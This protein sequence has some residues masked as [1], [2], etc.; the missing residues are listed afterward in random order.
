[1]VVIKVRTR[2]CDVIIRSDKIVK[3]AERSSGRRLERRLSVE[4]RLGMSF[5]LGYRHESKRRPREVGS[6]R[7]A[8]TYSSL[9]HLEEGGTSGNCLSWRVYG[10]FPNS[11]KE[12]WESA[13]GS[14]TGRNDCQW[15]VLERSTK[16]PKTITGHA[17]ECHSN[18]QDTA[19]SGT[20]SRQDEMVTQGSFHFFLK[21]KKNLYIFLKI[22]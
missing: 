3:T 19:L 20:M 22:K 7:L 21:K 16:T 9:H 17:L 6:H 5:N 18:R 12:K 1:V 13:G 2:I 15:H 14:R 10:S 8:W 11:H 4:W